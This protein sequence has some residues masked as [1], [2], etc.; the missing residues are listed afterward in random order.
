MPSG[1]N[2]LDKLLRKRNQDFFCLNDGSF[3]EVSAAERQ[4]RVTDFLT[5]YFPIP[6]PWERAG[7]AEDVLPVPER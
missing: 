1:L 7:T 3:P 6:A 2:R 5:R 4:Q